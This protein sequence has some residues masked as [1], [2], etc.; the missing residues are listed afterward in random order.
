MI[1]DFSFLDKKIKD[2]KTM[3]LCRTS[4]DWYKKWNDEMKRL[5]LAKRARAILQK[6]NSTKAL[7]SLD[8]LALYLI[9]HI[10][11][12]EDKK[13]SDTTIN[14]IIKNKEKW[15]EKWDN[16]TTPRF[17]LY[18]MYLNEIS[19]CYRGFT[20]IGY[21]DQCLH[22]IKEVLG[23]DFS[24]YELIAL[25]NK[26]QGYLHSKNYEMSYSEFNK[27]RQCTLNQYFTSDS[28][29]PFKFSKR[30]EE[31]F[32]KIVYIPAQRM[33]AECL[34][35]QQR[36]VDAQK[37]IKEYTKGR[38]IS[39]YQKCWTIILQL[40]SNI[41]QDNIKYNIEDKLD[42]EGCTKTLKERPNLDNQLRILRIEY[43]QKK[44]QVSIE[45][46]PKT[47]KKKLKTAI[48]LANKL[49]KDQNTELTKLLN[50][51]KN[52]HNK[53][54]ITQTVLLWVKGLSIIEKWLEL[55]MEDLKCSK[56]EFINMYFDINNMKDFH[57][58]ALN[59]LADKEFR[60]NWE[61]ICNDYLKCLNELKSIL[62]KAMN[63]NKEIKAGHILRS[64]HKR[65]GSY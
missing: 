31:L 22:I 26:G 45:S 52:N 25:F 28:K 59:I 33:M 7:D 19:A 43:Y 21:S 5:V 41:D 42:K 13:P 17:L 11:G 53:D 55:V 20:S 9:K 57:K 40:R 51:Q 24:P 38:Y 44:A 10:P 16:D 54:E 29:H 12:F 30:D 8:Y 27:I 58:E 50:K 37:I 1:Y 32:H 15:K 61:D 63:N 23:K 48:V 2:L 49:L 18:I 39:E 6:N 14:D 65:K 36:S 34:L 47:N 35:K 46:A 62:G 3:L 64:L 4:H 56:D 60:P